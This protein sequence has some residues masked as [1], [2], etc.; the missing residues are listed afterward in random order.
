MSLA[1]EVVASS[2]SKNMGFDD[3]NNEGLKDIEY[4]TSG[5]GK[6]KMSTK[7]NEN[8]VY[9]T[10]QEEDD[11][12]EKLQL[13]PQQ[14]LKEQYEK[15]KVCIYSKAYNFFQALDYMLRL[16]DNKLLS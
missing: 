14:T 8:P 13:G 2:T 12:E 11:A 16:F 7:I 4:G 10:D 15:D 6:E 1:V 5:P 9:A 3:D